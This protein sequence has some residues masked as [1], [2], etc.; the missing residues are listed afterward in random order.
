MG[1]E[2]SSNRLPVG[3]YNQSTNS[4][5]CT[6]VYNP[7]SV[8]TSS[9][10][11]RS[12]A[13]G[14]KKGSR[15]SV[16]HQP[17]FLFNLLH[18]AKEGRRLA[19][20]FESKGSEQ[21][22]NSENFQN[23][24]SF[25]SSP[26]SETRRLVGINRLKRCVLPCS[27]LPST[28]EVP[29]VCLSRQGISISGSSLRAEHCS[30]SFYQSSGTHYRP[31]SCKRRAHLSLLRRLAYRRKVK[32]YTDK[33]NA[34]INRYAESRRLHHKH[35]EISVSTN[36]DS[37]VFRHETRYNKCKSFPPRSED[38]RAQT[39]PSVVSKGSHISLSQVVP[40]TVRSNGSVNL[41]STVCK[42]LHETVS[43][44]PTFQLECHTPQSGSS[45]NGLQGFAASCQ[46]VV[47][48]RQS[49][50]RP[51]LGKDRSVSGSHNRC[52][53][54][55]LGRA[56]ENFYSTRSLVSLS[57][58]PAHQPLGNASGMELTQ[59]IQ[60]Q[61]DGT[62]S[63]DT[64]RQ[65]NSQ[66]V[67]QQVRR[68]QVSQS[69]QPDLGS[70]PVVH[71]TPNR[72]F[73]CSYSGSPELS[74]RSIISASSSPNRMVSESTDSRQSLPNMVCSGHRPVCVSS[75]SQTSQVL[76]IPPSS[77]SMVG[78]L[79]ES[80]LEESTRLCL[81]SSFYS[82]HGSS[83]G[84]GGSTC[85]DFNSSTV[86][87]EGLVFSPVRSASRLSTQTSG[88]AESDFTESGSPSTSQP[89]R[90]SSSSMVSQRSTLLARGLS[91][92]TAA[93]ILAAKSDATV[94]QYANSWGHFVRWCEG[95]D[96][97]PSSSTIQMILNYFSY[98]FQ[99]GLAFNTVKARVS[100]I[101]AYHKTFGGSRSG[102]LSL[103]AHPD[104]Q[105]FFKGAM[106]KYPPIRDRVPAWDLPTVL[107]VLKYTPFEPLDS[108]SLRELTHKAV[109]L[110]AVTSAKRLGELHAIDISPQFSIITPEKVV[111]RTNAN[112][113]PKNPSSQNIQEAVEFTPF[114]DEAHN[115]EGTLRAICVCRV[116]SAY[117]DATRDIRQSDQLFVTYKKG[118]QG[119]PASKATIASWL[120]TII[121]EAYSIVGKTLEKGVR[122]HSCRKQSVSWASLSSVSV[123]DICRQACWKSS[124]TFAR[125]YKLDLPQ[126]VS[127]RHADAVLRAASN[128][129]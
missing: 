62:Q 33:F 44:S 106:R 68:N 6:K 91:Q 111:L 17:R 117:I 29:Q 65:H 42:T 34:A 76:Y 40:E 75:Q 129:S 87:Q 101:S 69:V 122:A 61:V 125:H 4:F 60:T 50:Q 85:N 119:R 23:G 83:E 82:T 28:Q 59:S 96:I 48:P 25:P 2:N 5:N 20:C 15:R 9:A 110:L 73:S 43:D 92:E 18:S 118:D 53:R 35:Q 128:D 55:C 100:A 67:Y 3:V 47:R 121:H 124:T 112:F 80:E 36:S 21:I 99:K 32:R 41:A 38:P 123:A 115:P 116:L 89:C 27:N 13:D 109:L 79:S 51:S 105:A 126:T 107:Q 84:P 113:L 95:Q 24:D 39:L 71:S 114:G 70:I 22:H 98:C 30:K 11:R 1:S 94:R 45:N 81:S 108:L 10:S 66:A 56:Y 78:G 93:T 54:V 120:K 97:D 12:S 88:G 26:V 31:S 57:K 86:E 58:E 46:M 64:D 7:S 63:V 72:S 103:A 104:V 49:V 74:R 14:R 19:S 52:L 77:R 90:T 127:E 16:R 8:T 102:K 37:T